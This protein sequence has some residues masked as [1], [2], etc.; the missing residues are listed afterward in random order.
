[1]DGV[2]S[3]VVISSSYAELAPPAAL[4]P[5]VA[6]V[7][8]QRVS[9][10]FGDPTGVDASFDQPVLPDACLDLV[11]AGGSV[12]VAGPAT[13][14]VTAR[15]AP[16]SLTVGVRFRTGAAPAVLGVAASELRDRTVPV[17]DLWGPSAAELVERC[18]DA[19][20]DTALALLV[21]AVAA[22][23]A[24]GRHDVDDM[25]VHVAAL[26]ARRPDR[27]VPELAD[28]A[29]LSERQMRRRLDDAVGYSPRTLSRVVRF[30]RFLS[31][32]RAAEPSA[33][34]LATLA[35]SSGY[36]DQ[37]HLTRESNRLSGQPPA[38]LLAAEAD[39]LWLPEQ[40]GRP[41]RSRHD[42]AA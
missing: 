24:A 22:R 38:R 18:A 42:A 28:E 37:A 21:E 6:C 2:A 29:G 32:A 39:R 31:V 17:A 40:R 16:G 11:V 15:I 19:A 26:I 12:R 14:A 27:P 5:V 9:E 41:N 33:R 13:S 4:V 36:A 34:D 35:V 23:L 1:M 3:R 10:P 20:P 30:Q 8:T 7:W 25:A